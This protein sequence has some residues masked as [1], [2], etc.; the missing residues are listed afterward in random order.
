MPPKQKEGKSKKAKR[1][2]SAR[3]IEDATFGL[4]NKNKS[5]KVQTFINRVEKGVKNS[6]GSNAAAQFKEQKKNAKLKAVMEQE[7]LR[8]LLGEGIANQFGKKKSE[9]AAK[10]EK[11]GLLE[12]AIT[13][14]AQ[15]ALDEISTD[16]SSDEGGEKRKTIY[17]D[18]D[19][20]DNGDTVYH[21]KTLEDLIEE[22]RAKLQEQGVPGTPV[23]E[24]SFAAWK[25]AKAERK[26][27]E[28][29]EKVKAEQTKKKGGK[30]LA[31]LSGKELFNY[32]S[33]LF[34]DD[35]GAINKDQEREEATLGEQE[36][37]KME[38]MEKAREEAEYTKAQKEQERMMEIQQAE[39]A[40]RK[41]KE[42]ERIKRYNLKDPKYIIDLWGV[43]C[44]LVA[45]AED[46][47]EDLTPFMENVVLLG[48]KKGGGEEAV[49]DEFAK[50]AVE[51]A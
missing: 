51:E 20:E 17:L 19:E 41:I 49:E 40:A 11:F 15:A 10:A 45:F 43:P 44:N 34:K 38:A 50:M 48:K 2:A 5:K 26:R 31:V 16:E 47:Y 35:D 1:E 28:V 22:Q 23:T 6:D 42:E 37:A 39:E 30:G 36:R 29:E 24:E 33:T 12:S 8:E 18:S 4:K 46:E 9:A 25:A 21:E 27:R 13:K 3:A 32:D 7:Q 14:E